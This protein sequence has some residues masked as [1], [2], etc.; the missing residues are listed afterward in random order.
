MTRTATC[1]CGSASITVKDDPVLNGVCHCNDCK[2]RTGSAFGW[3]AYFPEERVLERA[4]DW[5]SYEPK[6]QPGQRR[7]VCKSCG[8]IMWWVAPGLPGAV[9]VPGGLFLDPPLPDPEGTYQHGDHVSWF[10]VPAHWN[11]MS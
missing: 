4:G 8:S 5:A 10:D 3:N 11:R 7:Y 9:G 2:R 1:C 6:A